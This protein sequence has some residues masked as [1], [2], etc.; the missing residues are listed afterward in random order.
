[1][2]GRPLVGRRLTCEVRPAGAVERA[3]ASGTCSMRTPACE[4]G[5]VVAFAVAALALVEPLGAFPDS[6]GKLHR[7]LHL[8]RLAPGAACPVSRVDR[9]IDWKRVNIFGG[10]G[11][12]RGP[13]YPG[14]GGSGGTA[15]A[16]PDDQYGGPWASGKVFW[17]VRPSYRGRVLIRGHRLDGPQRLGFNGRRLPAASCVSSPG[18]ASRGR[19][20]RPEAAAYPLACACARPAATECR[21]TARPSVGAW[22]LRSR[23]HSLSGCRLIERG[24]ARRV[25]PY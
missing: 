25:L 19:G 22:S 7:P 17:Y 15:Y 14:L 24:A 5:R 8:P 9:R 13:V 20:S 4:P 3:P 1:L 18:T 6:L 23:F 10:S 21:S 12:G 2:S 11:I 16:R